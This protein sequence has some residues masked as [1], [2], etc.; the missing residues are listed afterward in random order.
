MKHLYSY[1]ASKNITV[2]DFENKACILLDNNDR[3]IP[4]AKNDLMSEYNLPLDCEIEV[5]MVLADILK[6]YYTFAK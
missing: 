3:F 6:H 1:L 2:K 5:S 4:F